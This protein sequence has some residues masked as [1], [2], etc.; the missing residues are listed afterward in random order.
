MVIFE[1]A[2]IGILALTLLAVAS[3][4]N[5]LLAALLSFGAS[6]LCFILAANGW[7]LPDTSEHWAMAVGFGIFFMMPVSVGIALAVFLGRRIYRPTNANR[8][9][10]DRPF[11]PQ[12][13]GLDDP[14]RVTRVL[15][16]PNGMIKI[17]TSPIR[18][19]SQL[20]EDA[21]FSWAQNIPCVK[22]VEN[23]FL[24]IRSKRLSE[25]D[26]RDLIAIM[27]RYRMPMAQLQQFLNERNEHWFKSPKMYWHRDIFGEP[28]WGPAGFWP[29]SRVGHKLPVDSVG[30]GDVKRCQAIDVMS[31]LTIYPPSSI[32]RELFPKLL[33]ERL[34]SIATRIDEDDRG[35]L[36]LEM[37]TV[38]RATHEAVKCGRWEQVSQQFELMDEVFAGG[39]DTVRN[40]VYVSYLENALLGETSSEFSTARALLPIGLRHAMVELESHW[41]EISKTSR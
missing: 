36:H 26:L 25:I 34:P 41:D 32:D 5:A 2:V 6:Y 15:G 17:D 4:M 39:T 30:F 19:F 33:T 12:P 22:S 7:K 9:W 21:F 27:H 16:T 13:K 10:A 40:A 11:G 23:G 31:R 14:N 1:I 35:M 24:H 29:E 28:C 8:R 18:Y 37:A 38:A 3:G 20:D